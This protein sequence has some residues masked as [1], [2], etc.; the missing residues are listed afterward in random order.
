MSKHR[1]KEKNKKIKEF[2]LKRRIFI[3]VSFQAILVLALLRRLFYLQVKNYD[4]FK[5]LSEKNATNNVKIIAPRGKIFDRNGILLVTNKKLFRVIIFTRKK[6]IIEKNLIILKSILPQY[7]FRSPE[8]ILEKQK[9]YSCDI[10]VLLNN[11]EWNDMIKIE[12]RRFEF[13]NIFIDQIESRF[14]INSERTAHVLG[15]VDIGGNPRSGI[16][17]FIGDDLKGEDGSYVF[18]VNSTRAITKLVDTKFPQN[19]KNSALT[20]DSIMQSIVFDKLKE[21]TTASA[22]I[23]I[24]SDTGEV[25]SNCSYPSFDPHKLINGSNK[26]M[27]D[28]F[29]DE[30]SPL[31]NRGVSGLYMPGS[32]V[33]MVIGL[34]ALHYGVVTPNTTF[35]CAKYIEVG[36]HKFHCWSK[37]GH[38]SM[39]LSDAIS[40]SCD[41]YFYHVGMMLGVKRMSVFLEYLA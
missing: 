22:A 33:K 1:S 12:E 15:Y 10:C 30:L 36:N 39:N 14:Y 16:E 40:C 26:E 41:V 21:N 19:G 25:V 2:S 27:N 29:A 32:L 7:D 37:T 8:E 3:I 4:K 28:I 35:F 20:I 5:N 24:K 6:H 34:A 11:V 31:L 9:I 38:G 23:M 17:K 18:E 13:D